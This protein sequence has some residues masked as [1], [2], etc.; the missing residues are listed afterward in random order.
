MNSVF[1]RDAAEING[2]KMAASVKIPLGEMNDFQLVMLL[3]LFLHDT[4]E[5]ILCSRGPPILGNS[6]HLC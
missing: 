1:F 2:R 4:K 6:K 5:I 3:R